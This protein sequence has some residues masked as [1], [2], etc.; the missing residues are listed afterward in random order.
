MRGGVPTVH[1]VSPSIWAWRGER[2]R[3][4][5]RAADKVLALFPFEP[6]IYEKAGIPVAFVG[7]PLADTVP[8]VPD[9]DAAREQFRLSP[10]G[11]VF[12]LL[13]GSRQGE[14][15][16]HAGLFLETAKLIH[17]QLPDAHFLVPPRA[18]RHA[19][20]SRWHSTITRPRSSR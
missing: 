11:P 9:R 4:I 12:A 13:P 14:L 8:E 19:C 6:P 2:I 18:G 7:H 16:Q 15:A 3:K 20:S 1:Y 10:E 17:Q 5:K